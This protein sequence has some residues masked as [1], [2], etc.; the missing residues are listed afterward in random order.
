M[1]RTVLIV[2]H[3][4]RPDAVH[5]A[6]EA[7]KALEYVG[8]QP[9][10]EEALPDIDGLAMVMVLGGDGTILRA[11][12]LTYGMGVPLLGINLGHVGF[13]AESERE[14]IDEAVRRIAAGAYDVEERRTVDVRV[15]RPGGD[16]E[17]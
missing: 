6:A 2:T 12:E 9:V 4:G 11:A 5:A 13:L 3:S 14:D 8:L 16:V 1:N 17:V 10:T 15:M 7:W